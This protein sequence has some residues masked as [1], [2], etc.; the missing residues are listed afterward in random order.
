MCLCHLCIWTM[1]W[2]EVSPDS[3]RRSIPAGKDKALDT[4]GR[5]LERTGCAAPGT[6]GRFSLGWEVRRHKR[7]L[8]LDILA[9]CDMFSCLKAQLYSLPSISSSPCLFFLNSVHSFSSA[10]SSDRK[11][12]AFSWYLKILHF[13]NANCAATPKDSMW[14]CFLKH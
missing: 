13:I 10:N 6:R 14:Q 9:L 7:G 8:L 2:E 12:L 4:L 3:Q 11:S 5:C 1:Q